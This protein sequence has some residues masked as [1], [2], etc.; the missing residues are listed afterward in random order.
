MVSFIRIRAA[1]RRGR[2]ETR[3][4][5]LNPWHGPRIVDRE[6]RETAGHQETVYE[7]DGRGETKNDPKLNER[8]VAEVRAEIGFEGHGIWGWD[9]STETYIG[10]G[11]DST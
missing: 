6:R 5:I 9:A 2:A 10:V 4:P 1:P 11:V 7:A 3:R 8:L